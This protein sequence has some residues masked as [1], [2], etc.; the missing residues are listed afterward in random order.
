VF[1]QA[2]FLL[3][4]TSLSLRMRGFAKTQRSLQSW[5]PKYDSSPQLAPEVAAQTLMVSRMVLAASRHA[6]FT[7]TCLECSLVLWWLL[8]RHG[9]PAQLRIGVRKTGDKFEAHAW[10][11]RDGAAI[12]EAEDTHLHYA[13][14]AKEF[15]G[16]LP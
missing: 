16:G 12:A 1:V 14:F 9:V 5:L 3:P 13:P 4:V 11:E 10:V 2:A 8:A 7:T 15:T 6:L